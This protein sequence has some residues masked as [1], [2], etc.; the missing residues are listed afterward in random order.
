M[1]DALSYLDYLIVPYCYG[2]VVN[3][4]CT[5]VGEA[6]LDYLI[7]SHWFAFLKVQGEIFALLE[8]QRN[9][10]HLLEFTPSQYD[11][12]FWPTF[13]AYPH[14][15]DLNYKLELIVHRLDELRSLR[16]A[17]WGS[18]EHYMRVRSDLSEGYARKYFFAI[19]AVYCV[20]QLV[21]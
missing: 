9:I 10:I 18:Y 6:G 8:Q 4:A 13:R 21:K 16:D 17:H 1:L 2:F 15:I 14:P 20:Y 19:G 3:T 5:F 11:A 7:S 12:N